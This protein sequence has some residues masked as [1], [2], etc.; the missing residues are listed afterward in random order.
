MNTA[1]SRRYMPATPRT[2]SSIATTASSAAGR[3]SAASGPLR[4]GHH[5]V[6]FKKKPCGLQDPPRTC[7]TTRSRR[8]ARRWSPCAR[9][10][11]ARSWDTRACSCSTILAAPQDEIFAGR[12]AGLFAPSRGPISSIRTSSSPRARRPTI[13]ARTAAPGFACRPTADEAGASRSSRRTS[14]CRRCRG[15]RRRWCGRTASASSS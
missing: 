9:A 12:R 3:S 10:T 6:A 14:A 1:S 11:M 15:T 5:L 13:S 4:D 2:A 8:S 7:I